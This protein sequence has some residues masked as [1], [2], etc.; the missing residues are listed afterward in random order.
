[1]VGVALQDFGF[2]FFGLS[3][4]RD[5]LPGVAKRF[6]VLVASVEHNAVVVDLLNRVHCGEL[7]AQ[8]PVEL[9]E[10]THTD[11]G[12][13]VGHRILEQQRGVH[14]L[15]ILWVIFAMARHYI[16]IEV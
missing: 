8:L 4:D 5:L 1:V 2:D 13:V 3:I 6:H 12:E 15:A 9:L 10:D 14:A 11:R 16:F 7:G